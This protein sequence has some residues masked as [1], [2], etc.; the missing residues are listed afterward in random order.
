VLDDIIQ[1]IVRRTNTRS[2]ELEEI[3][4]SG[5]DTVEEQIEEL[6]RRYRAII[7]YFH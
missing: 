7:T 5:F 3:D 6:K 2:D 4:L 1:G